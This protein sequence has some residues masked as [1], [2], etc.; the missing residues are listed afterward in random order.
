MQQ[1]LIRH[2]SLRL[3]LIFIDSS[4][5]RNLHHTSI[6]IDVITSYMAM[7]GTILSDSVSTFLL[8]YLTHN[9][10]RQEKGT[11]H[12]GRRHT[13]P[14]FV[15]Y[16]PNTI[17]T[18]FSVNCRLVAIQNVSSTQ[19]GRHVNLERLLLYG[20]WGACNSS[21][22]PLLSNLLTMR[23]IILPCVALILADMVKQR[24]RHRDRVR[25]SQGSGQ[26]LLGLGLRDG[27]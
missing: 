6:G 17:Y 15:H 7:R 25:V 20:P 10:V 4:H 18:G 8:N 5:V 19:L 16:F 13:I 23:G 1:T 27:G 26:G 24:D 9:A 22:Q 12:H 21:F 2:G 14:N 11:C 3:T